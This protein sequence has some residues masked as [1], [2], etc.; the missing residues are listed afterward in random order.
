MA[1]LVTNKKKILGIFLFRYLQSNFVNAYFETE[2]HGVTRFGLGRDAIGNLIIII[3][4]SD[5]QK[6]IAS[7]L[8]KKTLRIDSIMQKITKQIEK[9]QEYR[10]AIISTAITG[11]I[12]VRKVA[13]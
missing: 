5:K 13:S 2:S 8:D 4:S 3:P 11:K 1:H 10:Q 9:L 7:F 6:Q 12:D